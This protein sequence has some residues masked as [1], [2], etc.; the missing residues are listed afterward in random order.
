M[1]EFLCL[2]YY[3][4]AIDDVHALPRNG[5][6]AAAI[7]GVYLSVTIVEVF[8]DLHL[9]GLDARDGIEVYAQAGC[10]LHGALRYGQ[11]GG[12]G[13]GHL[14]GCTLLGAP[15]E[16]QLTVLDGEFVVVIIACL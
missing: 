7:E 1:C 8:T 14:E 4:L 10:L 5:G 12:G 9:Q 3:F 6:T 2:T 13:L 15:V 11:L 16:A